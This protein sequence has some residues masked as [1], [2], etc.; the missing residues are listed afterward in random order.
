M[1]SIKVIGGICIVITLLFV[2][3]I[4]TVEV[5]YRMV[6]IH[7]CKSIRVGMTR[8]EIVT[9]FNGDITEYDGVKPGTIILSIPAPVWY[10]LSSKIT[11]QQQTGKVEQVHCAYW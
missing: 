4:T 2:G 1:S 7:K 5:R 8:D 3:Y 11:V 10:D 6:T 9:M